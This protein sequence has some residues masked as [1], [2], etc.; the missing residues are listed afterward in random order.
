MDTEC[1][2]EFLFKTEMIANEVYVECLKSTNH[3]E[4]DLSK[5]L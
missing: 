2:A 4:Q 5:W 3:N 1:H